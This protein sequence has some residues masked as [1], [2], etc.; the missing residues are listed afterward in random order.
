TKSSHEEESEALVEA[1]AQELSIWDG[2]IPASSDDHA[3]RSFGG[4]VRLWCEELDR[5]SGRAEVRLVCRTSHEYPDDGLSLE[6]LPS[7]RV[8]RCDEFMDGWSHAL[9][10]D[11]GDPLD[12]STIDWNAGLRLRE[13]SQNWR[14][15][16]PASPVRL[17]VN[18]AR[19][20]LSG[21]IETQGLVQDTP[22]L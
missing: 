22:F 9:V 20:G 5:I 7:G 13:T 21:Y 17:F 6:M 2:S 12:A 10:A 14:F 1:V 4:S 11:D 3:D 8:Y 18:A 19:V 15:Y 16:L